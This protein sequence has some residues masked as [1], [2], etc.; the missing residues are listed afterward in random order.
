MM[1]WGEQWAGRVTP[2]L[3]HYWRDMAFK[4][5]DE[6]RDIVILSY[7]LAAETNLGYQ[8]I[9]QAVVTKF[10]GVA[11]RSIGDIVAAKK[12]NIDS[13]YDVVEFEMDNPKV[14][15]PREQLAEADAMI[16]QNYGVG[17]LVNVE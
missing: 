8:D 10:N 5:S 16:A 1:Q 14:V 12:A 4:P 3:Y 13:K 11:V 6:R 2:H 15:M 9:G 7:V 17:K